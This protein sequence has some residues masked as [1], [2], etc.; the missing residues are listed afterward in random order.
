M[1]TNPLP[2]FCYSRRWTTTVGFSSTRRAI[3]CALTSPT[4]RSPIWPLCPLGRACSGEPSSV[5]ATNCWLA[6]SPTRALLAV[7][8]GKMDRVRFVWTRCFICDHLIRL[9][10]APT[11]ISWRTGKP[12]E[13]YSPPRLAADY[14]RAS[15]GAAAASNAFTTTLT[16]RDTMVVEHN[17][18]KTTGN[19]KR[20]Q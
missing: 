2:A 20:L 4:R 17:Y 15:S 5:C 12:E 18:Q 10:E 13:P 16:T 14:M 7:G 6:T 9:G 1:Y 19:G 11:R 8:R 3:S